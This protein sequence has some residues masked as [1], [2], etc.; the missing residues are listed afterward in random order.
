MNR[1]E[2]CTSGAVGCGNGDAK[3]SSGLNKC[4]AGVEGLGDRFGNNGRVTELDASMDNDFATGV[5]CEG[6]A[7]EVGVCN[8]NDVAGWSDCALSK[9]NG[10]V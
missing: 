8:G 4:W 7:A 2:V 1:T 3:K 6:V 9:L 10:S 5:D